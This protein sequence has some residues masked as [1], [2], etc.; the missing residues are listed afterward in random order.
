MSRSNLIVLSS[1]ILLLCLLCN[2]CESGAWIE[3]EIVDDHP[4]EIASGRRFWYTLVYQGDQGL[5]QIQLG[6]GVRRIRLLVPYAKTIIFAAYPLGTG[7]PFGGAY[8]ASKNCRKVELTARRGPLA[9]AL[10]HIAKL[11]PGPVSTLSFDK[12]YDQIVTISASGGCIDWNYLAT[13][14]VKGTISEDSVRNSTTVDVQLSELPQGFWKCESPFFDPFYA[15]VDYEISLQS[16]PAGIIR[17]INFEYGL[18]LRVVVP[19]EEG[20]DAFWHIVAMDTILM[21][22]D[23]AYQ[24]LL[25]QSYGFP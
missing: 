1:I 14:V 15:F 20:E 10:L 7:F 18:E 8:H 13:D 3:V 11:W 24:E 9:E 22:S 19:D 23:T 17:Y 12:L 4:W 25:E 5:K 21:I 6:I 2:A 16:L